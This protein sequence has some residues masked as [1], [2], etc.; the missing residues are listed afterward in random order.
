MYH[1]APTSSATGEA[2]PELSDDPISAG[3][4]EHVAG[5]PEVGARGYVLAQ[6]PVGVL[7]LAALPGPERLAKQAGM[8]VAS[9]KS[10]CTEG[11]C[12]GPCSATAVAEGLEIRLF[13]VVRNAAPEALRC[14]TRAESARV[15]YRWLGDRVV[16]DE[17]RGHRVTLR[18]ISHNRLEEGL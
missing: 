11:L 9:L 2:R 15:V 16:V 4:A 14:S 13:E 10:T 6:Q 7:V 12:R 5:E 1:R 17:G 18:V 3:A 8:T